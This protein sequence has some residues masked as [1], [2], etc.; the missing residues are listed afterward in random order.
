MRLAMVTD[1]QRAIELI[2]PAAALAAIVIA[3]KDLEPQRT[4][5]R[6]LVPGF[7]GRLPVTWSKGRPA[8][9]GL[10][11]CKDA[12]SRVREAS[13]ESARRMPSAQSCRHERGQA[14]GLAI[15]SALRAL[16]WNHQVGGSRPISM[17]ICTG[18]KAIP[19]SAR[20]AYRTR[21]PTC[22]ATSQ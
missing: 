11:T 1:E 17:L 12:A 4:P 3:P 5:A 22:R 8:A 18:A 19:V 14:R 6:G 16:T 20:P 7:P 13:H 9:L 21:G 2:Q 10:A 15:C